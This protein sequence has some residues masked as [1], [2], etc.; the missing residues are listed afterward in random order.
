MDTPFTDDPL[1]HFTAL[2]FAFYD[3]TTDPG[4][5][6]IHYRHAM[7]PTCILNGKRDAVM[8]KVFASNLKGL[9]LQW[10]NRLPVYNID[11]FSTMAKTFMTQFALSR[12][13][14]KDTDDLYRIQQKQGEP[15]RDYIQPFN[16]TK[17]KIVDCPEVVSSNAFRRGLIPGQQYMLT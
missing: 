7:I 15:L 13:Y 8:C 9:A 3:G 5:H 6:I 4:D 1:A 11:S 17:V 2:K 12:Q 10:F 14:H 16:D